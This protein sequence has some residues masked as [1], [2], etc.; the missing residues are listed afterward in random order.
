MRAD[1]IREFVKDSQKVG[2]RD[3]EALTT[4]LGEVAAQL[5]EHN[6]LLRMAVLASAHSLQCRQCKEPMKRVFPNN[7]R[8]VAIQFHCD[9]CGLT[10]CIHWATV[11]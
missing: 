11:R 8:E 4:L 6:E 1:E 9:G 7:L 2:P 5:D 3:D 10:S